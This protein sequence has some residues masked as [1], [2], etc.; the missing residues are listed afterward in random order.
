[1][2]GGDFLACPIAALPRM[3]TSGS[4]GSSGSRPFRMKSCEFE[5]EELD[6]EKTTSFSLPPHDNSS[7]ILIAQ[8]S[9]TQVRNITASL[10]THSVMRAKAKHLNLDLFKSLPEVTKPLAPVTPATPSTPTKKWAPRRRKAE[11]PPQD[12]TPVHHVWYTPSNKKYVSTA[13]FIKDTE[14]MRKSAEDRAKHGKK[15]E[16]R[17]ESVLQNVTPMQQSKEEAQS[18]LD[19]ALKTQVFSIPPT[20]E[21]FTHEGVTPLSSSADFTGKYFYSKHCPIAINKNSSSSVYLCTRR[22]TATVPEVH[23]LLKVCKKSSLSTRQWENLLLEINV[24]RQVSNDHCGALVESLHTD[25]DVFLV[26]SPCSGETLLDAC[27]VNPFSIKEIQDIIKQIASAF[28]YLHTSL[29]VA[30]CALRGSDVVYNK[31]HCILSDMSSTRCLDPDSFVTQCFRK[32]GRPVETTAPLVQRDM[33]T[34]GVL[35]HVLMY[36]TFPRLENP[37][38]SLPENAPSLLQP[39]LSGTI[40]PKDFHNHSW[41]AREPAAH[42]PFEIPGCRRDWVAGIRND[43]DNL[44]HVLYPLSPLDKA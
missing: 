31:G 5:G 40:M 24:L 34:L 36:G 9:P 39:L 35:F 28:N 3:D 22:K 2:A 7:R 33:Q 25:D 20:F 18:K 42:S 29:G 1:M 19:M 30:Y 6:F 32:L 16:V 14:L 26:L 37:N 17:S 15:M 11:L 23:H 27:S 13:T 41:F 10:P 43:V 44:L 12:D 21:S 4:S 38:S 8:Q